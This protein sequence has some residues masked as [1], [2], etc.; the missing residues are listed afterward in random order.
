MRLSP[1]D[2]PPVMTDQMSTELPGGNTIIDVFADLM[3]YLFDT[4][5]TEVEFWE[6]DGKPRWDSISKS[7]EL[8]LTHPNGWGGP[9]QADLRDA[10]VKAG[11][12]QD[13]PDGRSRVHFV[14]EGE[15][16]FSFYIANAEASKNLKVR[17]TVSTQCRPL[18]RS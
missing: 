13:T 1:S 12:V 11:I 6:P 2:L 7:I 15:A 17:H 4:T 14:S 10:A 9:Q 5:K 8:V 16:N 3:R 18:T